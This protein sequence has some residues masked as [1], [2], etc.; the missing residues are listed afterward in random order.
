MNE[1][2]K[3]QAEFLKLR[4]WDLIERLENLNSGLDQEKDP[5]KRKN[6]RQRIKRTRTLYNEYQEEYESLAQELGLHKDSEA[7]QKDFIELIGRKTSVS[8]QD[9]KLKSDIGEIGRF[10]TVPKVRDSR[11]T[12]RH[13]EILSFAERLL[14]GGA[15]AITGAKGM[16]G[17]GKTAIANELCHLLRKTWDKETD[18]PEYIRPLLQGKRFF[19][20]GILWIQFE[21][22]IQNIKNLTDKI[23]RDITDPATAEKIESLKNLTEILSKKDV[24]IVLDSVEQNMRSFHYVFEAFKGKVCIL[25]TSRIEI[26]GIHAI[27]INK[28]SDDE[29]FQLFVK[30]LTNNNINETQSKK[31]Q[32]LC[33]TLGNFPLAISIMACRVNENNSNLDEL[34]KAYKEQKLAFLEADELDLD[35]EERNLSVKSCFAMSYNDLSKKEKK[36]FRCAGIFRDLFQEYELTEVAEE[37]DIT[38]ALQNLIKSS[39]IQPVQEKDNIAKY[40][41]HPLMREFALDLLA[42]NTKTDQERKEQIQNLLDS[43]KQ[44]KNK[45]TLKQ[46]LSENKSLMP[47]IDKAMLDCNAM[48]EFEMLLEFMNCIDDTINTL[49]FWKEKIALNKLVIKAAI[50]LQNRDREAL[51]RTSLADTLGRTGHPTDLEL[52]RKEFQK[53]LILYRELHNI[54]QILF[55]LYSL[56]G[57]E[58]ELNSYSG[59]VAMNF[60]GVREAYQY[61][62][63]SEAGSF[64]KTIGWTYKEFHLD[65][66]FSLLKINFKQ[67]SWG[68][69]FQKLNY[70]RSLTDFV[71]IKKLKGRLRECVDLYYKLFILSQIIKSSEIMNY[72]VSELFY[73]NFILGNKEECAKLIDNYRSNA[74]ALGIS[75]GNILFKEAQFAFLK[76]D[77]KGALQYFSSAEK[78]ILDKQKLQYWLGK[79]HLYN[80]EPDKAEPYLQFVL[81]FWQEQGNAV[82]LADVYTQLAFLELQNNNIPKAIEYISASIKTKEKFEIEYL[83]EEE[84]IRQKIL[85][86][87]EQNKLDPDLFFKIEAQTEAIDLKPSFLIDNLSDSIT[88]KDGK[89]M[90]L[91]PE[92]TA[93]IG[94]GKIVDLT[95][96]GIVSNIDRLIELEENKKKG[97][98]EPEKKSDKEILLSLLETVQSLSSDEKE[99]ILDSIDQLN[100]EKIKE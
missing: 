1:Y 45:G 43:I 77:F 9:L 54:G 61:N 3:E 78:D 57:I 29:A 76:K 17:I 89:E 31:I 97:I 85:D 11:F 96:D 95:M 21:R 82:E 28:L 75:T 90:L 34:K 46:E 87:I 13:N 38:D 68:Q 39:F 52:S 41:L 33:E 5:E 69:D 50:A 44:A 84:E 6:I 14:K 30:H 71:G 7:G 19:Q 10:F 16:G 62:K 55:V 48:L 72:S 93:F 83:L 40:Q 63:F 66:S 80:N 74:K 53:A 37:E 49:G 56:A 70:I 32:E 64:F 58:Y 99:K 88:S 23:L 18:L 4:S 47:K 65:K 59:C 91:I 12:G 67:K 92:G 24:L 100:D 26:P 79:T 25:I 22:G 2:K 42:E 15:F 27:D 86:K 35:L 36:L 98:A 51:Y 73:F 8:N 94:R 60:Q 20:D 81:N